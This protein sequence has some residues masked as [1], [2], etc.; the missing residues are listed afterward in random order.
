ME[1]RNPVND[2]LSFK[3][4]SHASGGPVDGN[5]IIET[6]GARGPALFQDV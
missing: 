3:L 4:L 6:A 1:R 2:G 5:L